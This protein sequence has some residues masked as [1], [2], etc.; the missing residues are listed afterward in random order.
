[1]KNPLIVA[2]LLACAG[3]HAAEPDRSGGPF[4]PTPPAVVNA[5][6]K[7]ANVGPRD[8]V[9]DLGAGDGRIVLTAATRYKASGTGVEI[10][11]DLVEQANAAARSQGVA[12]RARFVRQD[13]RE[14]D[15]SRATVLTLYLLPGMMTTLR[16]KL[17]AELRPGS[18]VV[19]HDFHFEQWKPDRSVTVETQEKYEIT[20]NWT[21]EVHLWVVPARVQG[22]WRARLAD[23]KGDGFD[24]DIRQAFQGFDGRLTRSGQATRLREGRVSGSKLSFTASG[25]HGRPERYTAT[26]GDGRMTGE[27]RSGETV[28]ARWS[29][30][31][32]P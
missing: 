7:L 2:A 4:V 13:V 3:A 22:K 24:L 21:S 6:L 12:D 32:L 1:V 5:M 18:R 23:G 14:A 19:S 11:E 15:L 27:V 25:A 29:A 20:G 9:V 16:D 28:V 10:D 17:L 26:V 8:H 31:R 30:A